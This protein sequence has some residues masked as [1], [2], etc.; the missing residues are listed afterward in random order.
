MH[1]PSQDEGNILS[2]VDEAVQWVLL[3]EL[4]IVEKHRRVKRRAIHHWPFIERAVQRLAHA[5]SQ[6]PGPAHL[7]MA[8]RSRLSPHTPPSCG[9]RL[10]RSAVPDVDILAKWTFN[11]SIKAQMVECIFL[12]PGFVAEFSSRLS[13]QT[14]RSLAASD[15]G[16][17]CEAIRT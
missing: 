13:K 7:M 14:V 5:L 4:P 17:R 2:P 6:T 11:L 12:T 15:M 1:L 16:P 8:L 9:T 3:L 10:G